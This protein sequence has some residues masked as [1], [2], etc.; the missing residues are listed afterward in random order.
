MTN[1]SIKAP[2]MELTY[3]YNRSE[4]S[5][6]VSI[7]AYNKSN[8]LLK[9]IEAVFNI[10]ILAGHNTRQA[11]DQKVSEGQC[12]IAETGKQITET[13]IDVGFSVADY[14]IVAKTVL[15]RR[16]SRKAS[17]FAGGIVL[18]VMIQVAKV[19][20]RLEPIH[21]FLTQVD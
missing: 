17:N 7:Q 15:G 20:Q 1:I 12:N 6:W 10:F 13:M 14:A 3:S 9:F 4:L 21:L 18:G 2:G 5:E 19:Q 8:D 11:F 16:F